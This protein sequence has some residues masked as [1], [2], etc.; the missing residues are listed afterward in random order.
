MSFFG[1][2]ILASGIMIKNII[3]QEKTEYFW[4]PKPVTCQ[5]WAGIPV[6]FKPT[7]NFT[8]KIVPNFY[9]LVFM[10]GFQDDCVDFLKCR[11]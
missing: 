9:C 5:Y 1:I 10:V 3:G 6:S 11:S 4:S 7:G 8:T 2:F